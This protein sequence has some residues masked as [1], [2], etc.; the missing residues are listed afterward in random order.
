MGKKVKTILY[1]VLI[2]VLLFV[3]KKIKNLN[4]S[5][6]YDYDEPA[7][8]LTDAP[9]IP[10]TLVSAYYDISRKGR[11]KEHYF[12]WIGEIAKLDVPFVFFTQ[13]KF[14]KRIR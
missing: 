12:K 5:A 4:P 8:L 10:L 2:A 7:Q 13:A 6:E 11:P 14:E 1:F 9:K 3:F